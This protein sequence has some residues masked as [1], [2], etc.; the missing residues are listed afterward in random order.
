MTLPSEFIKGS[1][2]SPLQEQV[3]ALGVCARCHAKSLRFVHSG[4]GMQF[5][6]CT[7]CMTVAILPDNG[8]A[9]NG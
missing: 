4:A 1:T 3:Y 6:Q 2:M 9:S 8:R 7:I 5:W